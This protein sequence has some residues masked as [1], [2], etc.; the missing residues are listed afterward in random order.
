[1]ALIGAINDERLAFLKRLKTWPVFGVGWGRRVSEVRSLSM[2]FAKQPLAMVATSTLANAPVDGKGVMPAPTGLKNVVKAAP[3]A[4]GGAGVVA[5]K[6]WVAAHPWETGAIAVGAIVV[7]GGAIYLINKRHQ[8][9]QEAP[10]P[11]V[12]PV[13]E[14]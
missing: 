5:W 7:I 2:A 9:Q 8:A 12:M 11:G 13:P 10:T 4:A 6:D 14:L 3:V 1:M